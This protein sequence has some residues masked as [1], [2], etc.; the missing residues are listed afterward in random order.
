MKFEIGQ[1]FTGSYP[2]EAALWCNSNGNAFI[3]EI[4]E[5]VFQIKE[6]PPPSKDELAADVRRKR[7]ELLDDTLWIVERHRTEKELEVPTTLTP[8]EYL[9]VLTYQQ[10]L[11]DITKQAGFPENVVYPDLPACI[12]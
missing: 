11:R 1:I 4:S 6:V 10:A 12:Q 2:P 9:E 7:Q 8:K 3:E 5:G